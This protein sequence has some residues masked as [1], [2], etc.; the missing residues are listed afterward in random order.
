[1]QWHTSDNSRGFGSPTISIKLP[2]TACTIG[3]P[4]KLEGRQG[5]GK[6]IGSWVPVTGLGASI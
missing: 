3:Y 6:G 2:A 4:Q 5:G 1:M